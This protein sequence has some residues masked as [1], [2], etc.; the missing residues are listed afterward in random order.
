M[1]VHTSVA[2]LVSA[3]S[4]AAVSAPRASTP[5]LNSLDTE[6]S[7]EGEL[8][9]LEDAD[10]ALAERAFAFALA[11]VYFRDS[12][13]AR[14]LVGSPA[15]AAEV[16]ALG[17]RRSR[18]ETVG[19]FVTELADS[20][21]G[22]E[23]GT[24]GEYVVMVP[25]APRAAR[26]WPLLRAPTA[27]AALEAIV[28]QETFESDPWSR[29]ERWSSGGGGDFQWGQ[30]ECDAQGGALSLDAVRGGADGTLLGCDDPYPALV[31]TSV[32]HLDCE[33]L[34]GA[35]QAWLDFFFTTQVTDAALFVRYEGVGAVGWGGIWSGWW[36]AIHNLKQWRQLGDVTAL[37]CP[38]VQFEF[39]DF[40][41]EV[42]AGFGARI[43]EV[44]V[45]TGAV[46]FLTC[47][48]AADPT[49]GPAPLEVSF[50]S[51]VAGGSGSET[52]RWY[53]DDP[54][55]SSS[56]EPNPVFVYEQPGE[57]DPWFR[58]YDSV[59]QSHCQSH[60]H[61]SVHEQPPPP[62]ASFTWSPSTP[63]AGEVV[64]F[65]DTSTNSPT[66]WAWDFGDGATSTAQHPT[67]AFAA[68]GTYTV[69][70][71]VAN[72]SGSD[73]AS[74]VVTVEPGEQ[75]P[76]ANFTWAPVSPVVGEV[77]QFTD[78]SSGGPTS[79]AW[80]FG[81]GGA[82]SVANPTHAFAAPGTFTVTLTVANGAGS[83]TAVGHVTVVGDV[84]ASFTWSPPEPAP[85]E[86]VRFFDT[87]SGQPSSWAWSFGDGTTSPLQSPIHVFATVGRYTVT[88]TVAS[89]SSTSSASHQVT[90]A[91]PPGVE[92]GPETP[93]T[94]PGTAVG[95]VFAS[96]VDRLGNQ[97]VVWRQGGGKGIIRQGEGIFGRYFDLS[98]QGGD[99]FPVSLGTGSEATDPSVAFDGGGGFVVTWQEVGGAGTLEGRLFGADQAPL[100]PAF[101]VGEGT[102]SEPT[103]PQVA[104]SASGDFLVAWRQAAAK[105]A[106]E[107]IFGR[108]FGSDSAPL[109][110]P[111]RLDDGSAEEV[112][113]P[114]VGADAAGNRI[115][116]WHQRSRVKVGGAGDGIFGRP[117]DPGGL[118]V[119]DPVQINTDDSGEPS[120]PQVDVG[121]GGDGVAVWMQDLGGGDG[122]DICARRLR[123]GGFPIG[124][125]VR[126][127]TLA[128]GNQVHPAVGVNS[129]GDFVVAWE[130]GSAGGTSILANFFRAD[131]T[132][133]GDEFTVAVPEGAMVP[134]RPEVT[135]DGADRAIVSFTREGPSG[136]TLQSRTF[137][138]TSGPAS[139]AS[140]QTSLC[141]NGSRFEV[142]VVWRDFDG[143]TGVGQA[144]PLTGD[145]GAFWF[146]TP[147][148]IELVVK[149]LDGRWLNDHF[150][151]FYGALSN[152]DY[153]LTVTDTVTGRSATYYNPS[154]TF[155]SVGDTEA[156]PA[157][158]ATA[159][160]L[161]RHV[162][163]PPDLARPGNGTLRLAPGAGQ[164]VAV[165]ATRADSCTPT[166]T[167]LC[168]NGNRFR[169]AVTW[170][171]F[172]G[173]TGVGQA[174]P[175]T[176]DTGTFW[177][178][179]SANVELIVKVLD[180]RWLNGH[181]WVFYGSLSNVEYTI[182]VTDTATG[183]VRVYS[184]PARHFGSSGDTDAFP[185]P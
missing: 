183:A 141:L 33:A 101:P 104:A 74:A 157:A 135:L 66:S 10:Q 19:S 126:V 116:V 151:V 17:G 173:N 42:P 146:F 179:D 140:G 3:L 37:P 28:F 153:T 81:D 71:T 180:G 38:R 149:V 55:H 98:G 27:P 18:A 132:P 91:E 58:V 150:W 79:W 145:T 82:A 89:G 122:A 163:V 40:G 121:A 2:L 36:H 159:R 127:N 9:E 148:N 100:G 139:C 109:G 83:D 15:A 90:V 88:L 63:I 70:L 77:V 115:V 48:A 170:R 60:L 16:E 53:F 4:V 111:V 129:Q 46:P 39:M 156:I 110:D 35:S 147:T 154:G 152:V 155:A 144:A 84:E 124:S 166:A 62:V 133:L 65:T 44:T 26:P 22:Y 68:A 118:P 78:L 61:I 165:A 161:Q 171:D 137:A 87:S 162:T 41:S 174:V 178:F 164:G 134:S 51:T 73:S 75:P 169:V 142:G 6:R 24:Q 158:G 64:Q 102:G 108:S 130:S 95:A 69:T 117:V 160:A 114:S 45:S 76:G 97:V 80:G 54:V 136:R 143:N 125:Q 14:V 128:A 168:L 52:L 182:T 12:R 59:D 175:L 29:W 20:F 11:G 57:Y 105:Q 184:N 8:L 96:A 49:N 31:V 1:R 106:G 86:P 72:A 30:T 120:D 21:P 85:G 56:T 103:A 123:A 94:P 25:V 113:P 176:S 99:V 172:D 93:V 47:A 43:D 67:H 50:T 5:V 177:F 34:A 92:P 138:I 7:L 23:E 13:L 167:E 107:G 131:G 119:G 112:S 32:H 185:S 181:Y